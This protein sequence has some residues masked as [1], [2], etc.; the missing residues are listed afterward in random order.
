MGLGGLAGLGWLAGWHADQGSIILF[1]GAGWLS[2]ADADD[3]MPEN[4]EFMCSGVPAVHFRRFRRK[5]IFGILGFWSWVGR[6]V[7]AGC[8]HGLA[9]LAGWAGG[10]GQQNPIFP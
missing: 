1:C 5:K 8:H 9:G 3:L 10:P 6:W 2:G 4:V 7:G